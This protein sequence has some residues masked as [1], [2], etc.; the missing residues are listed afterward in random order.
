MNR[1]ADWLHQ[2]QADLAQAQLSVICVG[3]I[4]AQA[5]AGGFAESQASGTLARRT[6]D[7]ISDWIKPLPGVPPEPFSAR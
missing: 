7:L 4:E 5:V 2:A 1:S 6:E 3:W